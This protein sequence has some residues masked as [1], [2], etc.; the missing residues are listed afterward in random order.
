MTGVHLPGDPEPPAGPQQILD[1]IIERR[2]QPWLGKWVSGRLMGRI[3]ERVRED[4]A[5]AIKRGE[6]PEGTEV[7]NVEVKAETMV[8]TTHVPGVGRR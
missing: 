4:I 3:V 7:T 1:R 6:L 8:F 5:H 2:S